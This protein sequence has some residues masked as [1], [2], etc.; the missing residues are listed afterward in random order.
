MAALASLL[1]R[2]LEPATY[3]RLD[4][5]FGEFEA[6][7][8]ER[9]VSPLQAT[10]AL[11]ALFLAY[12]RLHR[13]PRLENS[14]L[15]LVVQSLNEHFAR[16]AVASPARSVEVAHAL[17]ALRK[18]TATPTNKVAALD[19]AAMLALDACFPSSLAGRRNRAI[20]WCAYAGLFRMG[21]VL[22]LRWCD[23]SFLVDAMLVYLATSK[24]QK[25][26]LLLG[27]AMHCGDTVEIF[28]SEDVARCC[29]RMLE[30]LRD[31]VCAPADG[32][33]FFSTLGNR[34]M[35]FA[36]SYSSAVRGIKSAASAAG[37]TVRVGGH[38]PRRSGATALAAADLDWRYIEIAGRWAPGSRTAHGYVESSRA[39]RTKIARGLGL[40]PAT[41]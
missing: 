4:R 2:R 38:T 16:A 41:C 29:V 19:R 39:A 11:V 26:A 6:Y 22:A 7:A 36:V 35:P 17:G 14:T 30:E 10:P 32:P 37:L 13:S 21:E 5:Y 12:C 15:M 20:F 31:E 1:A 34:A 28:R 33:V 40:S 9:G 27:S 3:A 8:R 18:H 25:K 23:I 24:T